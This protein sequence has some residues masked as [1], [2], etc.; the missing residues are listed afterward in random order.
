MTFHLFG[1]F[2]IIALAWVL[3]FCWIVGLVFRALWMG[4]LHLTGMASR[5]P[6]MS[7]KPRRC[8]HVR[9][10]TMNPP[11][12]NFCRRC[13]SSLTR[14]ANVREAS[15]GPDRWTSRLSNS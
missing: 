2:A 12:A 10:L 15:P 8:T 13:G 5:P 6:R 7:A 4:V 1:I 9:C 14:S 11:Q 3:F